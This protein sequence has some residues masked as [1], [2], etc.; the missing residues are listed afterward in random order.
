M[1]AVYEHLA[2]SDQED[3]VLRLHNLKKEDKENSILFPKVYPACKQRN[4]SDKSHCVHCGCGLSKELVQ[5]KQAIL[6]KRQNTN[7]TI[8]ERKFSKKIKNL[9]SLIIEQR[10]LMQ[11]L[12]SD[13][14]K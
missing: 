12:I 7:V 8:L 3:A 6:E 10:S 4:S 13:K 2:S 14:N 1:L 5:V 11:Q 9:E